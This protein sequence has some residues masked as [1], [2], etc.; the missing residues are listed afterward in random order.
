MNIVITGGTK[1]I[2]KGIALEFAKQ[3]FNVAICARN[4]SYL[5]IAKKELTTAA[6][7]IEIITSQID[8]SSKSQVEQFAAEILKKWGQVDVLVNNAASFVQGSLLNE[9]A[10]QLE[11]MIATNV[12]G[13]YYLTRGLLP[14]LIAQGSG[15][16]FN[17]CSVASQKVYPNCSSYVIAKFALLGFS[18]VLRQEL[19]DKNIKVTSVLPGATLTDS[20]AGMDLPKGRIMSPTDIAKTIW[21]AYSLSQS[22]V[23]EEII[24]RPQ[25]GDL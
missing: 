10:G 22:A 17:I 3:G 2:G 6:P 1:G 11:K 9:P 7:T 16:I 4:L 24:I 12:Y 23:V 5:E 21:S 13:A 14:R 8:M 25:L 20:W 18:K 15:H 19:M